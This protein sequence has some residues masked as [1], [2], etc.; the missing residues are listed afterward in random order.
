MDITGVR[1]IINYADLFYDP[2]HFVTA[3]VTGNLGIS[4]AV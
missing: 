4:L 2:R 1:G 3:G